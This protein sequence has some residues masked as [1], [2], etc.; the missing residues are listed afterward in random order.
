MKILIMTTGH[1]SDT[2]ND[3][4]RIFQEVGRC[5]K[6]KRVD[7]LG[8]C[9]GNNLI[10]SEEVH[11]WMK[12]NKIVDYSLSA[13]CKYDDKDDR[14]ISWY[15]DIPDDNKAMLFKLTWC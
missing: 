9:G 2:Y 14:K 3:G 1:C 10:L 13:S 8:M 11:N 12:N 15:I 4:N 6:R 5:Y 7:F